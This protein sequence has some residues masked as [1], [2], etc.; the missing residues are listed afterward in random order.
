M[1]I[2]TVACHYGCHKDTTDV[3]DDHIDQK[4]DLKKKLFKIFHIRKPGVIRQLIPLVFVLVALTRRKLS[5]Y[6]M[7]QLYIEAGLLYHK[8]SSV[9]IRGNTPF[10]FQ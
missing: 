9:I 10:D 2:R 8:E 4:H 7:Y 3:T 5:I 1:S 6:K